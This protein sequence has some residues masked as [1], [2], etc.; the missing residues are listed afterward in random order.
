MRRSVAVIGHGVVEDLRASR[1]AQSSPY[2][3]LLRALGQ[4]GP[5]S[6][7]LLKQIHALV[8][9]YGLSSKSVLACRL[10]SAYAG[11]SGADH[12]RKLF[13]V[14]P[15]RTPQAYDCMLR[16]YAN[17]GRHRCVVRLY[18]LMLSTKEAQ[19]GPI[20]YSVLL[21]AGVESGE[22]HV[23][24]VVHA[25]VLLSG[26]ELDLHLVTDFVH[27]YST[28]GFVE[29]ARKLF[30][31]MPR[32]DVVVW[33]AMIDGLFRNGDHDGGLRL[34]SDL[35]ESG[36]KAN[37]ATWNVLISGFARDDL[38]S[39]AF[40]WLRLMQVDGVKPDTVSLCTILPLVSQS[41]ILKLGLGIHAY[42][43]R[44]GFELDLF[45]ASALV[46]M[47]AKCG[48]L[49]VARCLFD[50]IE[51]KD[52]GLWNAIIVGYGMHGSCREALRLFSQMEDSGIRPNEITLS[53]ILSACSHSG[54]VSEGCWVFNLIVGK[55]GFMPSHEHYSCMVDLLGRAGKL[56]E[57][58]ALISNMP[59][60][61]A[62]DVWGALLSAC[63][64]HPDVKLAEVVAQ[65]MLVSKH[66]AQEAG[67]LVMMSNIYADFGQ[68]TDV[69]RLRTQIRDFGLKKRTG[70]SWIEVGD[71]VHVF[72]MFDT[73]HPQSEQICAL[74]KN[75]ESAN[76]GITLS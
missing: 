21:R 62:K 67:Y 41:A 4:G 30:A 28:C 16:A 48:K 46:D 1:L 22:L 50:H 33:T 34:F 73:S 57:A 6:L 72:K 2:D 7:P 64:I 25:H 9:T 13:D 39:E 69:A 38:A 71:T 45:V 26:C 43:I 49:A 12:A 55:Y 63:R 37:T 60:E 61:P 23:G 5:A 19:P 17:V 29:I 40:H 35:K 75:L 58:F 47:Y 36:L 68:W 70:Y 3:L 66:P 27:L 11:V 24:R 14:L 56:D 20:T 52:T 8:V 65:Q 76:S 10:I 59:V 53:S 15:N 32:K 51:V 18:T 44:R 42:A 74:L 54:L 31:A